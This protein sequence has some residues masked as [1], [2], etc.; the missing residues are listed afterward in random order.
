MKLRMKKMPRPLD[1]R[2][3]SGASG[4]ATSSGSKPSPWSSTRTT[5]SLGVG[6]GRERELDGHELAVVLAVAVLDGVDDRFADGDADPVDRVLVEAGEL[7]DAIA[8]DLDEVQHVEVTVDLQPDG[9]AACQHAGR[10][11]AGAEAC[12][13]PARVWSQRARN[14]RE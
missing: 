4:S 10:S 2:M 3:F 7:P 1:F 13:T 11:D 12:R 8:H 5:S 14:A 9:A 6:G